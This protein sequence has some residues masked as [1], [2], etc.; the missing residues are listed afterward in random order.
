MAADSE[1]KD[2]IYITCKECGKSDV[3]MLWSHLRKAHKMTSDEYRKKHGDQYMGEAGFKGKAKAT[4]KEQSGYDPLA[5]ITSKLS[6]K[7]LEFYNKQFDVLY[8]QAEMDPAVEGH[9]RDIILGQIHCLRMQDA[10][11]KI[12]HKMSINR[13]TPADITASKQLTELIDKIQR[14]GLSLM[15]SLNL[16]RQKKM[17]QKR[18]VETTPSRVISSYL[19]AISVLTQ[20]QRNIEFGDEN[21]ALSRLNYNIKQ[22]S[23]EASTE[24]DEELNVDST[25]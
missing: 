25:V 2:T 13:A 9:I 24:V 12:T 7:E 6:K 15:E 3:K 22:L 10:L 8:K 19:Q 23:R 5:S 11:S 4:I 20:E 18:S 21:E 1:I 16:T 14:Q 17:A